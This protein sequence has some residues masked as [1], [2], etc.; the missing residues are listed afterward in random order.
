VAGASPE[1][2]VDAAA[3]AGETAGSGDAKP[4]G[5]ST[6]APE[7]LDSPADEP[8]PDDTSPDAVATVPPEAPASPPADPAPEPSP[9][10]TP[11]GPELTPVPTPG[12][13]GGAAPDGRAD[14]PSTPE[15]ELK[16]VVVA[17]DRRERDG[18]R[19]RR[20]PVQRPNVTIEPGGLEPRRGTSPGRKDG[21]PRRHDAGD[22][23]PP[24]PSGGPM[25]NTPILGGLPTAVA[26]PD[27]FVESFRIP[28]LLLPIYQAAGIR[29]GVRWEVLAAINEIET[30]YGRNLNVSSAGARGWMQFMPATW[31]AY[32]VDANGDGAKNPYH[33][34]D[35]I[36]AAARYL[37]AAGAA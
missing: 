12:A 28:P 7:V 6:A 8:N 4:D 33:P 3:V 24:A 20:G 27:L 34:S 11:A 5:G 16:P 32:G 25:F 1:P 14:A 13:G 30:D 17:H 23:A 31:K 37:R 9:T 21:A 15:A 35:A 26:V 22:A 29:Y 19:A 36:F 18:R 10:A 2:L